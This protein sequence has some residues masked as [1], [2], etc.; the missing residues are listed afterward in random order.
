VK[1]TIAFTHDK[2]VH[3][4]LDYQENDMLPKGTEMTIER[5][6]VTGVVAFAKEMEEKGLGKPKVS[7]QFE[8]N[9]SGI[10]ALVK[11]EA[12]VEET[13]TVEEEVEVDDEDAEANPTETDT[14]TDVNA[15]EADAANATEGA[16]NATKTNATK[17]EAKKPK[18]TIK[19]EKVS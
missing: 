13:Y 5:Y 11:A 12:A 15:T 18:K 16:E 1:K 17:T 3:C 4:A 10:T 14:E 9:P 6:N 19:V 8:L 7:L 2:D